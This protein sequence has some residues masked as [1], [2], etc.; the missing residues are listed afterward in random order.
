MRPLVSSIAL[1]AALAV[2]SYA[3]IEQQPGYAI[4]NNCYRNQYREEYVPGTAENPGYVRTWTEQLEIPCED[5]TIGTVG[6]PSVRPAIPAN[7]VADAGDNDCSQGTILGGLLGA[8]IGGA[9]SRGKG[10]WWAVPTGA[11]AGAMLGCQVDGG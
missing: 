8:G 7:P 10:R 5:T 11:A 3:G 2:P 9:A 1:A 4:S 6:Q